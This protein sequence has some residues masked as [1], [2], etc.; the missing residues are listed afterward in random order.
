MRVI[1]KDTIDDLTQHLPS[2]HGTILYLQA[3]LW[4][5]EPYHNEAFGPSTSVIQSLWAGIT[6][7]MRWRRYI[8]LTDGVSLSNNWI[9]PSHYLTLELMAHTGILHQLALFLSFPE[10]DIDQYR[11]R[12]TG[13]RGIESVHSIL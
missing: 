4:I 3:S 5:H 10:M 11:L 7:L 1:C 8:E 2:A 6:S 9:S 13:N 12:N